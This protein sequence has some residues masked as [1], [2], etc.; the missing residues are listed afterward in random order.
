LTD[1]AAADAG[2]R[3]SGFRFALEQHEGRLQL[4][5]LHRSAY[6]GICADWGSAEL[7]RR[8]AGGR[9]Q[10]L[11]RALGLHKNAGLAVLDANAGL[12]R[13]GFVLAALGA[14][15]TLVERN[16]TV[17]ELLGDAHRRALADPILRPAAERIE[18]VGAEAAALMAGERRWDCVYLDPMY[19][20]DGKTALPSKELQILRDLTGGDAD[21]GG[22]LAPARACARRRV[23]V[24]RPPKARWL[25]GIEPDLSLRSSLLRFD[26]YL[27]GGAE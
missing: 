25:A 27:R 11:A 14:T 8:I 16:P 3:D 9:R 19:P 20:D 15:V 13:D 17:L 7:R 10:P 4:R 21:A 2:A 6:G 26:V 5:A 1:P 12:G 24:K 22:L 18:L 23:A